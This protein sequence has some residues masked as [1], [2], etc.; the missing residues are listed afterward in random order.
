M[1]GSIFFLTLMTMELM[2][3]IANNR[4]VQAEHLRGLSFGVESFW[5]Y[6]EIGAVISKIT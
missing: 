4:A 5:N 2:H 1:P 3:V 6:Y